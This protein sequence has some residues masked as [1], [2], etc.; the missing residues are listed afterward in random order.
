MS[1]V[2][3]TRLKYILINNG[4]MREKMK[5][6]RIKALP[7]KSTFANARILFTF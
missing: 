6:M 4:N 5:N 1:F 2:K 3:K 7:F